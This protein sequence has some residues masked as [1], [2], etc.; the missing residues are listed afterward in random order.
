MNE[1]ERLTLITDIEAQ[2][3][4]RVLTLVT[5]DRQ[6]HETRLARDVIPLVYDHLRTFE[7]VS[8][9]DLFLYTPGGDT[10]AAWGLV[11]LI[12][13]YC[14]RFVVVVP[15]RCHSAGTLIGLGA[16]EI[17]V[18][19]G[20]QLGPID[21]S[22]SSPYNPAPPGV[23]VQAGGRI[24]LLPV[25]VE[26]MLGFLHLAKNEAG[27]KSEEQMAQVLGL[28][29]DKV[30]P[31]ALGA[32]YRAREHVNAFARSLLRTHMDSEPRIEMIVDYLAKLPTHSYIISRKE[33]LTV[34]GEDFVKPLEPELEPTVWRLYK[35]YER[36]FQLTDP[37]SADAI[38]GADNVVTVTFPRASLESR[39]GEQLKSHVFRTRKELSRIQVTQ[40][41]MGAPIPGIQER[42]I[43]EGWTNW[44]EGES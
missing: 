11:S 1:A 42:I 33:A 37:Y 39:E 32:V 40:P 31:L 22:V 17:L 34:F 15:F 38:L 8:E 41:G 2:R 16:D 44:P 19:P 9:I 25:S 14:D 4:A 29:A 20:G 3:N 21:P 10:L 27:L 18:A 23:P 24:T 13:E 5:G 26:D 7:H 28:M 35:L 12:R 43:T 6:G 30:H 36:W